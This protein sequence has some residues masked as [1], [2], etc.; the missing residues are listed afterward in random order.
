VST[1]PKII[2]MFP[3]RLSPPSL[4]A[5]WRGA[6]KRPLY[7]AH[8]YRVTIEEWADSKV[9]AAVYLDS[10]WGTHQ[11]DQRP[12]VG[13]F[14]PGYAG[15]AP[16]RPDMRGPGDVPEADVRAFC[17]EFAPVAARAKTIVYTSPPP[18]GCRAYTRWAEPLYRAGMWAAYDVL[19]AIDLNRVE[20]TDQ[21][22]PAKQIA[23]W[24]YDRG[25]PCYGEG[26]TLGHH[27]GT[28]GWFRKGRLAGIIVTHGQAKAAYPDDASV[29]P[30]TRPDLDHFVIVQHGDDNNNFE[31]RMEL[32][33]YW[34]E[35]GYT[36]IVD[37]AGG[38]PELVLRLTG[39]VSAESE[40]V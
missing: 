1:A 33:C 25:R 4:S 36:P 23:E 6:S 39:D 17:D 16:L 11:E 14:P 26:M 19:S 22:P 40:V 13:Y 12:T 37:V 18:L 21:P 5:G 38:T 28:E 31:G 24:W 30:R 7:D 10:P 8:D 34:W 3:F 29:S 9:P 20:R 32:A 35:R 15:G 27:C 2:A